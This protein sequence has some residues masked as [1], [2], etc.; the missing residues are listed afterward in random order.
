MFEKTNRKICFTF[1][2]IH[3]SIKALNYA[4]D[5][6]LSRQ[7]FTDVVDEIFARFA[8][9]GEGVPIKLNRV[10]FE[11]LTQALMQWYNTLNQDSVEA[12]EVFD[13]ISTLA[14]TPD[15]AGTRL[16]AVTDSKER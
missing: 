15:R 12:K 16:Y 7:G 10:E 8:E 3:Y 4:R 13:F 5:D 2:Q 9:K 11:T 6:L 14:T 1:Q